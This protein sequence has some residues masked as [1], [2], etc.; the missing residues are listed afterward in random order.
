MIHMDNKQKRI[1]ITAALPYANGDLHLGHVMSTYLPADIYTRYCKLAGYDALYICASDEHGTPIEMNATKAGKKP[2]EF[3]KYYHDRQLADFQ[4][5]GIKFDEYYSTNSAENAQIAVEFF[6]EHKKKGDIYEKEIGQNY[7][8]TDQRFL[9]DRF[10]RGTCPFCSATDQYGDVCEKCGK[11]YSADKLISPKCAVCGKPPV[12]R[13]S[14]HLFFKLSAFSSWLSAYIN[15]RP[16]PK[17]VVNYLQTWIKEGLADWDITRDGPYFGIPIPGEENK[18]FYVW[19][20]AP[21][22]YVSSTLHYCNGDRAKF[23]TYWKDPK[24][25][26]VHFIGKDIIYFHFLF[27]PAMLKEAGYNVPYRIPVRG[28]ATLNGEKMSKSRGTLIGLADF[29]SRYPADFLRYYYTS[30]TPNATIDANFS[31]DEFGAKVNNEF[32]GAACNYAYRVLT[33]VK[34]NYESTVPAPKAELLAAPKEAEFSA[35]IDAFPKRLAAHL[36]EIELKAGLEDAMAFTS[37]CNRYFNDRAPWKLVKENPEEA[38]AVVF[39]ATK[40]L[41][42]LSV[43]LS[44]FVPGYAQKIYAQLGFAGDVSKAHWEDYSEFKAGAKIGEPEIVHRPIDK[45]VIAEENAK[46]APKAG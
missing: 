40:A 17:D 9:P 30:I 45:K 8:E 28:H 11:T 21:I 20:D 31:W 14:K 18:F 4:K 1:L 44:P 22:G 38:K 42:S 15:E 24:T 37:E 12:R 34:N 2:E 27:W 13:K 3:V 26:I 33:F 23:E 39:L 35:K 6:E 16:F 7:C 19:Y 32:V 25:E 5:L 29:L 43:H 41:Y 10:L 46:I 36:E